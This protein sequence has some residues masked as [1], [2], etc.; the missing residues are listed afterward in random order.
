MVRI[1][2]SD[3]DEGHCTG[4]VVSPHLVLTAAHWLARQTVGDHPDISLYLGGDANDPVRARRVSH[5]AAV[6]ATAYDPAFDVNRLTAGHD[7]G[8]VMTSA[9]LGVTPFSVNTAKAA[10][11]W[12]SASSR[13]AMAAVAAS[14][15]SQTSPHTP[16]TCATSCARLHFSPRESGPE[17]GDDRQNF[18]IK[19]CNFSY[20]FCDTHND[21]SGEE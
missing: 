17:P 10:P 16:A 18:P 1:I 20:L 6:T 11:K 13:M 9:P 2:N 19:F 21:S 4:V 12:W 5:R 8:L 15:W 14:R 7:L 3:G